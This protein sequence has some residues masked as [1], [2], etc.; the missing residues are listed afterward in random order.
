MVRRWCLM[1]LATGRCCGPLIDGRVLRTVFWPG[2]MVPPGA[3][4]AADLAGLTAKVYLPKDRCGRLA[5]GRA[6]GASV[7]SCP[8]ERFAAEVTTIGSWAE[9]TP[10]NV[11]TVTDH[12]KSE[13]AVKLRVPNPDLRLKPGRFADAV[14]GM[15]HVAPAEGGSNAR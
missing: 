2:E 6:A 13:Y 14:F 9:F 12:V 11:Q 10:L 1:I 8:G 4:A 7:D 15:G 3:P 5:P